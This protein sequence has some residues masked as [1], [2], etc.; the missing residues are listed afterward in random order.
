MQPYAAAA[1]EHGEPLSFSQLSGIIPDSN[2]YM[3]SNWLGWWQPLQ[4]ETDSI[5]R[6]IGEDLTAIEEKSKKG[7][8]LFGRRGG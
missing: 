6:Q 3:I 2:A 7:F 5:L 1:K 8:S 4:E